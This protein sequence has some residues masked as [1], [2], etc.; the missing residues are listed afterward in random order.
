MDNKSK[1]FA[2]VP[3]V[4]ARSGAAWPATQIRARAASP[5]VGAL[6]VELGELR[7]ERRP[8]A[9]SSTSP[10]PATPQIRGHL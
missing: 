2:L 6:L 5:F 8:A 7:V 10:S 9:G 3:V 1:L 4:A